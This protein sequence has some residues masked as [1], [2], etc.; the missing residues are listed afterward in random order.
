LAASLPVALGMALV[1]VA[2]EASKA[3]VAHRFK[4][5]GVRSV[6]VGFGASLASVEAVNWLFVPHASEVFPQ[7]SAAGVLAADAL[8]IAGEYVSGFVFHA[9]TLA[10]YTKLWIIKRH[11]W[12]IV[13]VAL[14]C[15]LHW[16]L[17]TMVRAS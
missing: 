10:V 15:A 9:I 16:L 8:Y 4:N 11:D 1:A 17:N 13:S 2:E 12:L 5:D 14:L 7:L 3:F 6:A